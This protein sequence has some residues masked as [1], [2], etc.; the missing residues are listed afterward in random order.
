M[1]TDQQVV[2]RVQ[3]LQARQGADRLWQLLE[4]I[5]GHVHV[6]QADQLL[7]TASRQVRELVL[8]QPNINPTAVHI[9]ATPHTLL[10]HYSRQAQSRPHPRQ[11]Q[12]H[13]RGETDA[14][15]RWQLLEAVLA[16]V[17]VLHAVQPALL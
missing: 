11:V 14:K 7:H 4:L 6:P 5:P 3:V 12:A 17:E 1:S 16:R 8:P 13:E 15:L 2:G 9:T 10:L